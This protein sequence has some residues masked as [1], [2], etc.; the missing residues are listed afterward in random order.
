M[1]VNMELLTP[2][3][4]MDTLKQLLKISSFEDFQS[5]LEKLCSSEKSWFLYNVEEI[6]KINHKYPKQC[7]EEKKKQ[8]KKNFED[9]EKIDVSS[10]RELFLLAFLVE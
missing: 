6:W 8:M 3:E 4:Y 2:Q 7:L 9:L 10:Q 1:E 5:K